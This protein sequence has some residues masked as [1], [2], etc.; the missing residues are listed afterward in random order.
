MSATVQPIHPR[1][2]CETVKRGSLES[3]YPGSRQVV[4]VSVDP[5]VRVPVGPNAEHWTS[6]GFQRT[7]LAVTRTL[8]T[9][10][11]LLDVLDLVR[12][13]P[14][15]QVVFTH[16]RGS[17]FTD[18]VLDLIR[19]IGGR[20]VPWDQAVHTQFD[21]AIT[22]SEAGDLHMLDAPIVVVPHGVGHNKYIKTG[23][24]DPKSVSGFRADQLVRNGR[25]V[26]TAIVL[27][28]EE[29]LD[30]LK[31]S[32]PEALP[33]AVVA[34]D[35]CLDRLLASVPHR[36]RYRRAL[37]ITDHQRLVVV[38]STWGQQ[39][40]IARDLGLA[41]R[42]PAALPADEYRV[43]VVLHPSVWFGHSPYQVR[44][45]L[46]SA[47]E[48]GVLLVPPHEGWRATL[49]AAD[50]LISDHGSISLYGAALGVPLLLGAFDDQETVPT[51]PM[52]TLA[53]YAP[54]LDPQLDLRKQV[55]DTIAH[56][57]P[58][59]YESVTGRAFALQ[60]HG[61]Q[62]LRSLLYRTMSLPEDSR[63][64]VARPV[65][66]PKPEVR[67]VHAYRV[68]TTIT[69]RS[70]V[71]LERFPSTLAEPVRYNAAER[72]QHLAVEE[73]ILDTALRDSASVLLSS[74][75]VSEPVT[76]CTGALNANPTAR[77][78]ATPD[79]LVVRTHGGSV[80]VFDVP[81]KTGHVVASA[82]YA[83]IAAGR[84]DTEEV[85]IRLGSE[86]RI[87][88]VRRRYTE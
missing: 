6:I 30:Q 19:S 86:E 82:V 12:E 27:S 54:W 33:R 87:N 69:D 38:N 51:T 1:P 53:R 9:T 72:D 74:T 45:W 14:R 25:V 70:T 22:A 11:R 58:T 57:D 8:T 5:P 46:H 80:E 64:P 2:E 15:V 17:A 75:S 79:V 60:G 31:A 77:I 73:D 34:G 67:A 40:V 78:A 88:L 39:S 42:L 61:A 24:G 55:E 49:I 37:G 44:S 81:S 35:V 48:A 59:T 65:E 23:I 29:Q 66:D 76:W 36:R 32:C 84:L 63:S 20:L 10:T 18:G 50:L 43:A 21:L 68:L 16:E 4:A 52:A 26:P 47:I 83:L 71:S 28:H 7:V 13:D 56:H 3:G 85:V 62:A 41:T